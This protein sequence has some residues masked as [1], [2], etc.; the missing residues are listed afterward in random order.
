MK[1]LDIKK[2]YFIKINNKIQKIHYDHG[3][4]GF[5]E[6]DEN[7]DGFTSTFT[8]VHDLEFELLTK[9]TNPEYFL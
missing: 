2:K 4:W 8:S 5:W 9:D 1:K 6:P 3:Y 7:T